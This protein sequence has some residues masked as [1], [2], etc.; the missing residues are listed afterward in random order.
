[1]KTLVMAQKKERESREKNLCWLRCPEYGMSG[2]VK[3]DSAPI[4]NF[5]T[6]GNE[7][8][9]VGSLNPLWRTTSTTTTTI[10]MTTTTTTTKI[11]E[12]KWKGLCFIV[13]CTQPYISLYWC[14]RPITNDKNRKNK[15]RQHRTQTF[16][17][18]VEGIVFHWEKYQH[19][20]HKNPLTCQMEE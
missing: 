3:Y 19:W 8:S 15:R 10:L 18:R 17:S 7:S 11:K 2:K 9:T 12:K 14:F 4:P 16:F 20:L 1:M 13:A 6:R 5:P